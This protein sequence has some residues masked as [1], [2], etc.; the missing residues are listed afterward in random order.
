MII[1]NLEINVQI[2]IFAKRVLMSNN[3][4]LYKNSETRKSI[5]INK[6]YKVEIFRPS[7]F[8][9]RLHKSGILIYIFWYLFT[10]GRYFIL[11]IKDGD[12]I[13]HYSHCF[14][15]F[16]KFPFMTRKDLEI[17]PCWTDSQYRG[18]SLYP[19]AISHIYEQFRGKYKN[20]YIFTS[21]DNIASQRGIEKAGFVK[22]MN[23]RKSGILG[24]YKAIH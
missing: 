1:K 17:G 24:K 6:K 7:L 22:I 9:F 14:T 18:Q 19:F 23:L 10:F 21:Q 3:F 15:K 2:V 8:R 11:Y 13:I 4:L 12:R 20:F 16:Y 5:E